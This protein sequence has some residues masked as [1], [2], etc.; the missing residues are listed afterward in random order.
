MWLIAGDHVAKWTPNSGVFPE[1]LGE[2]AEGDILHPVSFTRNGLKAKS[3]RWTNK[4]IPYEISPY[5]S[6]Y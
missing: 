2:Y 3:S 4:V 6:K 1:E 5:M